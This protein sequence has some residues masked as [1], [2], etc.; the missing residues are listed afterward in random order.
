MDQFCRSIGVLLVVLV[1][2]AGGCSGLYSYKQ[3][4]DKKLTEIC[5]G[6]FETEKPLLLQSACGSKLMQYTGQAACDAG[7]GAGCGVAAVGALGKGNL[8]KAMQTGRLEGDERDALLFADDGCE[9]GDET[10]CLIEAGLLM[11]SDSQYD[12][13]RA[14]QLL[15]QKCK[16]AEMPAV[17]H[18]I[19]VAF[20]K[21]A[22][23]GQDRKEAFNY[24][25]QS[26]EGEYGPGCWKLG[27]MYE[28]GFG[29]SQ[30]QTRA[31]RRYERAC[32]LNHEKACESIG[33][34]P[35]KSDEEL[36][37]ERVQLTKKTFVEIG[38]KACN[39]GFRHACTFIGRL[40]D[41]G[42]LRGRFVD[43]GRADDFYE[44]GC[45]RG[46]AHSCYFL[47]KRVE[48]R[49]K[50]VAEIDEG[51]G[52]AKRACDAGMAE[53]C[54]LERDL[55]AAVVSEERAES[56]AKRCEAGGGTAGESASSEGSAPKVDQPCYVAGEAFARSHNFRRDPRR[57]LTL[58]R[59]GC[60]QGNGR[61]CWRAGRLLAT[62][63]TDSDEVSAEGLFERACEQRSIPGCHEL[64]RRYKSND[65]PK[66]A[67]RTF[68]KAC[69]RGHGPS[70]GE[71]ASFYENGE[72]VDEDMAKAEDYHRQ[73]CRSGDKESCTALG[74]FFLEH[75]QTAESTAR[76]LKLLKIGC[77]RQ[78]GRACA[79]LGLYSSQWEEGPFEK[80]TK[81]YLEK[82]CLLES[83]LG[84]AL[85]GQGYR[86]GSF[87]D[88]DVAKA[89]QLYNQACNYGS[90][91]G[92][93]DLG[94]MY[95]FGEGVERDAEQA[96]SFYRKACELDY[97][98]GC[99]GLGNMKLHDP[100]HAYEP[101]VAADLYETGC[102]FGHDNSC[103]QYVRLYTGGVHT[104]KSYAKAVS[105]L[106]KGCENGA[107]HSCDALG[108]WL[109]LGLGT[110]A[111]P[112]RAKEVSRRYTDSRRRHCEEY[113]DAHA[114]VVLAHEI[115]HGDGTST[116]DAK[117]RE[118]LR[119]K[120][121]NGMQ[122]ACHEI[123]KLRAKGHIF[124]HKHEKG[125]EKLRSLCNDGNERACRRAA[126][127][128]RYAAT[129]HREL[130]RAVD[131]SRKVCEEDDSRACRM[132]GYAYLHGVGVEADPKRASE[133]LSN[134]CTG[135]GDAGCLGYTQ[136]VIEAKYLSKLD[137]PLKR[138]EAGCERNDWSDCAVAGS[139]YASGFAADQDIGRAKS[140]Y[141]RGC[142]AGGV[143]TC[144]VAS[145]LE[146]LDKVAASMPGPSDCGVGDGELCI[147]AG[148]AAL[149]GY[150]TRRAPEKAAGLF[151]KA[152]ELGDGLGCKLRF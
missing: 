103:Q 35:A 122:A 16:R 65:Q 120:C 2:L 58:H 25:E 52:R 76:G 143:H 108:N 31:K 40:I 90:G 132:T 125:V 112:N 85:F 73:G 5:K 91:A 32:E 152:C 71:L 113:G 11:A 107:L 82:A 81:D 60:Q 93:T 66:E 127:F 68:Q 87:V 62:D 124:P 50:S 98:A 94:D 99:E 45:E 1:P 14:L 129:E 54:D 39:E 61:S 97:G 136:A 147:L 18:T 8:S 20:E 74:L 55:R 83:G 140:L 95:R 12:N 22:R 139:L 27:K 36:L 17:C 115:A 134:S 53:A 15:D 138:A 34:E 101:H 64:G 117:G 70:C 43:D 48:R 135:E 130:T 137:A 106:E 47:A 141:E 149:F 77:R 133:I 21:N 110:D 100:D 59:T 84:C 96:E 49:G 67:V 104:E 102:E 56:L 92:C 44:R 37:V 119:K 123:A 150:E 75:T 88:K 116:D 42:E 78:H 51:V 126:T 19:G 26:C 7:A 41:R 142:Q 10:S 72:V 3:A 118:F 23:G 46:A 111:D 146:S 4:D 80:E 131:Y 6:G 148:T 29:V 63:K 28:K 30:S 121:E 128:M 144:S 79:N 109:R 151:E 105:V 13:A 24:F 9:V 38:E 114:C 86:R 69:R 145:A 57:A 89:V 33:G